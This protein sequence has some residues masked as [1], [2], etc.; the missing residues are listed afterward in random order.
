MGDAG[1]KP[2]DLKRAEDVLTK[3]Q[4]LRGKKLQELKEQATECGA[5]EDRVEDAYEDED[6][7]KQLVDLILKKE[8]EK[9][10]RTLPK[11][12]DVRGLSG[13]AYYFHGMYNLCATKYNGMPS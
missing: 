4:E 6:P 1:L 2:E 12:I 7:Q 3:I 5:S 13:A 9:E 8:K 11:V 10:A